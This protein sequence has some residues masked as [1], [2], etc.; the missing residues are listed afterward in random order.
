MTHAE[1]RVAKLDGAN[2][3]AVDFTGAGLSEATLADS[4]ASTALASPIPSSTAPFGPTSGAAG[5]GRSGSVGKS[6]E[7]QTL[8]NPAGRCTKPEASVLWWKPHDRLRTRWQKPRRK[9]LLFS[10][11]WLR[12]PNNGRKWL[13][14]VF[15][16]V[17][18]F[19][20]VD[21]WLAY[22]SAKFGFQEATG[23]RT[24]LFK[25]RWNERRWAAWASLAIRQADRRYHGGGESATSVCAR[26]LFPDRGVPD[27]G[28]TCRAGRIGRKPFQRRYDRTDGV[29]RRPLPAW[30]RK[31]SWKSPS[32]AR[33]APKINQRFGEDDLALFVLDERITGWYYRVLRKARSSAARKPSPCKRDPTRNRPWII[34]GR[35]SANI[36]PTHKNCRR[37][38]TLKA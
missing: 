33:R 19:Y 9:R 5:R 6:S 23:H 37:W 28:G 38:P 21:H 26:S 3:L 10:W 16:Q 14:P 22:L 15:Q 2:L 27:G 32:R 12:Q 18:W 7:V 25:G 36:V 20:S 11:R 13:R 24:G 4:P 8:V 29:H 30:R 17:G 1:L 35:S 34:S 31:W